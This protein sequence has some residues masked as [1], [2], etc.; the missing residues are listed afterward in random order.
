VA[1]GNISEIG[2]DIYDQ[3]MD[4]SAVCT[5]YGPFFSDTSPILFVD[6]PEIAGLGY[7]NAIANTYGTFAPFVDTPSGAE[8][9]LVIYGYN[10]PIDGVSTGPP[11][12]CINGAC[13]TGT[14]VTDTGFTLGVPWVVTPPDDTGYGQINIPY[15]VTS[16]ATAGGYTLALQTNGGGTSSSF[17]V[18]PAP[19]IQVTRSSLLQATATGT[20]SGFG[21]FSWV[22]A[23]FDNWA[24]ASGNSSSSNP[25]TVVFSNGPNTAPNGAPTPGAIGATTAYYTAVSDSSDWV[26]ASFHVP[27]FGMSCYYVTTQQQWGAAPSSCSSQTL[28]GNVYSGYWTNPPGLPAG[29]YCNAYLVE[30]ALQGSGQNSSGTLVHYVSGGYPPGSIFQIISQLTGSDGTPVIPN[31]SVARDRSIIPRGGVLV[32][33]NGIGSGLLA[34]DTGDGIVGYR[35]DFYKELELACVQISTTSWPYPAVTQVTLTAL[36]TRRSNRGAMKFYKCSML[37]ISSAMFLLGSGDQVQSAFLSGSEIFVSNPGGKPRQLTHDGLPKSL[38]VWSPEG[39]KIAFTTQSSTGALAEIRVVSLFGEPA[40]DI[41]FRVPQAG[42]HIGGMRGVEELYWLDEHR[43][44]VS[45]SLNPSTVEYV[46]IDIATGKEITSYGTDGF[47]LAV[48][49]KGNHVAYKSWVPH[50]QA[51]GDRRPQLCLD[52]ECDSGRFAAQTYPGPARHIEFVGN[53]MCRRTGLRWRFSRS[54][55]ELSACGW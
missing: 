39:G 48:S 18:A 23:D 22:P 36:R 27:T 21:T 12:I 9:Y 16:L 30:V 2:D 43:L 51:E 44:A 45:G 35:L 50:F 5:S 7:L 4:D 46:A 52:H 42:V 11:Q 17:T 8:M 31:G 40:R 28:N 29:Q 3:D 15:S 41:P 55:T 47:S 37:F 38:L 14:S 32:D 20:P 1:T 6:P 53:P 33:A 34:N 10:L 13:G 54:L 19:S 24:F 49:P 25:N 26:G